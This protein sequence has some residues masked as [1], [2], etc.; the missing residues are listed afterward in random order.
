MSAEESGSVAAGGDAS[1]ANGKAKSGWGKVFGSQWTITVVGGLIVAVVGGLLVYF[2]TAT[3]KSS[4]PAPAAPVIPVGYYVSGQPS[5]PHWFMLVSSSHGAAISG[6]LAFVGQDG[7]TGGAQ[8][9]SGSI[10]HGLASL[11]F[12]RAGVRTALV[13]AR[14][15]PPTIDLGA[16]MGYLQFVT[17]LTQ[18]SFRH[19]ADIQGNQAAS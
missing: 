15:R 11:K 10:S 1:H 14:S 19:A 13:D 6:T 4:P 3:P 16:C 12:S 8:T 18:C 17:S 7:Q 9:F 2:L 5:T